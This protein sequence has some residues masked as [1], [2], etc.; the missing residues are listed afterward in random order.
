[1]QLV[2]VG[3][4]QDLTSLIERI[5]QRGLSERVTTTGGVPHEEI[6]AYVN[7]AT[8][9]VMPTQHGLEGW[10]MSAVE[11]LAMGVPVVAPNAGPFQFMVDDGVCGL[12]YKVDSIVDLRKK[13]ELILNDSDLRS[14]LSKGA[15][16]WEKRRNKNLITF[17]Q[18][19]KLAHDSVIN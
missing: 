7:E 9:M 13:I 4:G 18:A 8:L 15:I 1:V 17:G 10:G 12:L 5:H 2:Y 6:V 3:D 19:L 11:A 16:E 14:Q